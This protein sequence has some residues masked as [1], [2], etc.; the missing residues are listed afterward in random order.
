MN[1]ILI[2]GGTGSLGL[3][4][5]KNLS[6]HNIIS[7]SRNEFLI[8][9][10]KELYP[11]VK[12]VIGDIRDKDGIKKYFKNIDIVIHS[13]AIKHVDNGET[14]SS[15]IIKTNILGSQNIIDLS[16]K[17]NVMQNI[18]ISS[19][20]SAYVD[21]LYGATK[22]TGE[23][24]FLNSLINSKIIRFGNLIGSNGSV[25]DLWKN[26]KTKITLTDEKM[27]RFFISKNNASEFIVECISNN[28][29]NNK[30][31]IPKIKA[32]NMKE[33]ADVF[34]HNLNLPILISGIRPGEKI[35][36]FLMTSE[37]F[38]S[39]S[40]YDNF[41]VL[42]SNSPDSKDIKQ[43]DSSSANKWDAKDLFNMI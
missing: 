28:L 38:Y 37:E 3:S 6:S 30:I 39:S 13:A 40:E 16:T 33:I 27:S 11:D 2:S 42:N 23:R 35:K 43:I 21:N 31:I 20:K 9:K 10:A 25:F 34:S 32:I 18:F 41:W 12:F 8:A 36:E 19:D 29:I 1:N 17:Y 22:L 15:E 24:L 5:I 14:F 7:V 26:N 4:L